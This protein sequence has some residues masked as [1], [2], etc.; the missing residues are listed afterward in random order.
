MKFI[1]I[2]F[3]IGS[4]LIASC[5][6]EPEQIVISTEMGDI[7]VE[8][9]SSTPKHR[10]NFLKLV[11]EGFYE[12]T[13]FHRVVKDFMIQAGDP[14][15]KTATPETLLGNGG[16]GYTIPSEFKEIH[17]RGALSAARQNDALNPEK[18]SSGS[19]FFIVQG[20]TVTDEILNSMENLNGIKYTQEQREMYL[21]EGGVPFLDN[22][23]SVFGKVISGMEVVDKIAESERGVADRP[24]K[25]I[26]IISAKRIK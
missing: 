23:F 7:T 4:M 22:Q 13:L 25:D 17:T 6:S 10:K 5:A 21:K 3:I 16:P 18:E 2:I 9:Y 19:Q 12:G 1:H 20:T 26:K 15:S 14:D 24:L 11:D 8:L